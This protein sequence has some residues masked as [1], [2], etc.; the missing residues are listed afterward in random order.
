MEVALQEVHDLVFRLRV[1]V[2]ELVQRRVLD[3]VDAVGRDHVGDA[4][5]QVLRLEA[6]HVAHGGEHVREVRGAA[7]DAVAVVDLP[8]AGLLVDVER[9]QVAVQ[10]RVARRQVPPEQCRVRREQRADV[11]VRPEPDEQQAAAAQPLVEVRQHHHRRMA[12]LLEPPAHL[13]HKP[14]GQVPEEHR[15]QRLR[16]RIR[17]ADAALGEELVAR[18]LQARLVRGDVEEH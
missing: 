17:D 2:L 4:L 9:G 7:L 14:G 8:V 11:V 13:H 3:E 10:V 16:V 18:V 15:V 5:E 6:G 1:Q 12:R